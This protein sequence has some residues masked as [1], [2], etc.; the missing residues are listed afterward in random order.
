MAQ[1]T[2][3]VRMDETLK[4]QFDYLCNEF[5]INTSTAFTI[6]AKAVVREKKIP[7]EITAEDP[8]YSKS[9]VEHLLRSIASVSSAKPHDLIEVSDDD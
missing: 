1:T 8:F 3:S 6:F 4:K 5:G 2:V 9:N 7:F